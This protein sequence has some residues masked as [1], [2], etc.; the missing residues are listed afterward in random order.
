MTVQAAKSLLV[1]QLSYSFQELRSDFPTTTNF[2][3]LLETQQTIFCK[4]SH[5]LSL[6]MILS[7]RFL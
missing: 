7:F 2:A 3:L 4:V 5:I 1:G 6:K